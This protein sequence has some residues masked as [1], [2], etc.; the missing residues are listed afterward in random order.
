MKDQKPC[1]LEPTVGRV[2]V[3]KGDGDQKVGAIVIPS[4]ATKGVSSGTIVADG[5]TRSTGVENPLVGRTIAFAESDAHLIEH[6]GKQ[7]FIVSEEDILAF[8]NEEEQP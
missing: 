3:Q 8:I 6:Q 7:Y 5:S 1:P 2:I 4:D